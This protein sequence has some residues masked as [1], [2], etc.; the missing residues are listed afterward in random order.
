MSNDNRKLRGHAPLTIVRN[1]SN[2]GIHVYFS[3]IV[4]PA[5]LNPDDLDRLVAED[6]L[7]WV[8]PDGGGWKLAEAT[9]SGDAGDPVTVSQPT[10]ADPGADPGLVNAATGTPPVEA[11]KSDDDPAAA[12]TAVAAEVEARREAARA[13]LPA[14]GSAPHHNAGED[15]WREYA[16]VKGYD[17]DTVEKSSKEDL[18]ALFKS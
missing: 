1:A 14:D 4:D 12:A 10:M 5:A 2:V 18:K 13:K 11:T 15:V 9:G 8:V 3:Q 16:V 6:F 17:R 7:E